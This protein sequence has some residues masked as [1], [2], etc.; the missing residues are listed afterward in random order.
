MT[1]FDAAYSFLVDAADKFETQAMLLVDS[2]IRNAGAPASAIY[3]HC[4][5]NVSTEF[6]AFAAMRGVRV[7]DVQ[8]FEGGHV[9]CNKITQL[10]T[11]DFS[12][13]R[14]AALC[15]CDLFFLGRPSLD[16]AGAAV[17]GKVVDRPNPPID[18]LRDIFERFSLPLPPAR[19]VD[20]PASETEQTVETNWNGGFYVIDGA[21]AS[22]LGEVWRRY[23]LALIAEIDRLGAYRIHVDQIAF[24]LSIGALRLPYTLLP[25]T[26]NYPAHLPATMMRG[27]LNTRPITAIHYHDR[28]APDCRLIASGEPE[29]DAEIDRANAQIARF[30]DDGADHSMVRERLMQR[31]SRAQR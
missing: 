6:R 31:W 19:L 25:S 20:V 23:A 1:A 12:P 27:R 28:L 2:L 10:L 9:Y 3:A 17:A 14:V 4:T 13:Y 16:L 8:P 29:L 24:A 5:P 26:A 18:I 22:R 15:D 7:V 21:V 11:T 30:G